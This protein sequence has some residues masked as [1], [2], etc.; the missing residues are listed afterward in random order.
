MSAFDDAM[1]VL[2]SLAADELVALGKRIYE[3]LA[4]RTAEQTRADEDVEAAE[5]TADKA[6]AEKFP[7]G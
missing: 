6:Q 4:R 5:V 3:T 1:G 7:D 2:E